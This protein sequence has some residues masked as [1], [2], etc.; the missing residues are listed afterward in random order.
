LREHFDCARDNPGHRESNRHAQRVCGKRCEMKARSVLLAILALTI[1]PT[2]A[3]A[4]TNSGAT[5][6]GG[7]NLSASGAA[8]RPVGLTAASD[9]PYPVNASATGFVTLDVSVD[10][11]GNVQK[12]QVVRDVPPLTDAAVSAVKKWQF[13]AAQLNGNPVAGRLRVN[14]V[15]NPFNPGGVSIPSE[16]LKVVEATDGDGAGEFHPAEVTAATY[17]K[18]PVNTVVSGTVVLDVTVGKD[19]KVASQKV[20]QGVVPLTTASIEA[21]TSWQFQ[22]AKYKGN[23]A[24]SHVGVAFVFPSPALGTP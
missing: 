4:Q 12:I 21:V 22:A 14:A 24:A 7:R 1:F 20:I 17:A 19:G 3:G 9:I 10:A 13:T 18:Y 2:I 11:S 23:P 6:S 15:F 5:N 8:Y 16:A